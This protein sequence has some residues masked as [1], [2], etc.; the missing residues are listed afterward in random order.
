MTTLA[1]RL[2]RRVVPAVPVPFDAGGNIDGELQA[3]YV[4]WMARQSVG[5]VAVWAHTGRGL[6]LS[7][8]QR[9]VTLQSWRQG[10]GDLPIVAGV[11]VPAHAT[12]PVSPGP[13][14]DAVIGA[15]VQMVQEAWA[16]GADGVL[17]HPPRGLC[18]LTGQH[19]RIVELHRAVCAV[20]LPGLAFYLY[21]AAGGVH[22]PPQLIQ[23]I[24][25]VDGIIGIKVA[26]LDS[27]MTF[28]EA[29]AAAARVDGALLVTGEDRFLGY[30][31]TWGAQAAL[32]GLAAACTDR[33][34]AIFE[35]W[36][37]EEWGRYLHLSRA[38]DEFA[39]HTFRQPMEGYVQRM[40]WALEADGV[41]PRPAH[42]PYGPPLP[43][44]ERDRVFAAVRTLRG[45]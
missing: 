10:L 20:G 21:E 8:E 23:D 18:G 32:V 42:D 41:L 43:G 9:H 33:P 19:E 12:L 11:G 29:A 15:T 31:V 36:A 27:V 5:G 16:N 24:L 39:R 37:Q 13:R 4:D 17:V 22:Y 44:T 38:V 25:R 1:D 2:L 3:L 35:A 28:Q 45:R 26:T 7:D 6:R 34:A 40:L 14:T 30:T